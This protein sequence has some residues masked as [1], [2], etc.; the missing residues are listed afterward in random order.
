MPISPSGIPYP[1]V[2]ELPQRCHAWEHGQLD[3]PEIAGLFQILILT[4][5]AWRKGPHYFEAAWF[6]VVRGYCSCKGTA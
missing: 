2:D 6:M 5:L 1:T 3:D 4:G